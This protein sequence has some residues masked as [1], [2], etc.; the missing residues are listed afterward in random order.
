MQTQAACLGST[1]KIEE[2]AQRQ[3]E[4]ILKI[5]QTQPEGMTR[6]EITKA[7][8]P[9]LNPLFLSSRLLRL[10]YQRKIQVIHRYGQPRLYR[11][12]SHTYPKQP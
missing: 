4:E 2:I 12:M 5:L 9:N 10:S 1:E 7:V 11:A 3:A 6:T 8:T